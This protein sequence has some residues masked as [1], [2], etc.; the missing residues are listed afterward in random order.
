[1]AGE[2]SSQQGRSQIHAVELRPGTPSWFIAGDDI[3]LEVSAD[4]FS[5]LQP[6]HVRVFAGRKENLPSLG[7]PT[8]D[9]CREYL[10]SVYSFGFRRE[11][12]TVQGQTDRSWLAAQEGKYAPGYW[13][14]V[15]E[16]GA[17]RDG[18]VR[19]WEPDLR[20][21][22][23]RGIEIEIRPD[24]YLVDRVAEEMASHRRDY[25]K[26]VEMAQR[27]EK[28]F[29]LAEARQG[30]LTMYLASCGTPVGH[31]VNS[32]FAFIWSKGSFLSEDAPSQIGERMGFS[33][34][35]Y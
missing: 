21:Y 5:L 31:E 28:C 22:F 1:L 29:E 2:A 11:L 3:K 18:R 33:M 15:F 34:S 16:S 30:S 6:A 23:S 14:L 13:V 9:G 26:W 12:L 7:T 35:A 25:M 24:D 27:S 4:S 19:I 20:T 10:T 8:A 17:P 32:S